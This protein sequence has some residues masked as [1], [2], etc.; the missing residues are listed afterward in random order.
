MRYTL[1]IE[2]S[3]AT[4]R[5]LMAA[6]EKLGGKVTRHGDTDEIRLILDGFEPVAT[7]LGA[8]PEGRGDD[9]HVEGRTDWSDERMEQFVSAL[10]DALAAEKIVYR[11]ELIGPGDDDVRELESAD[12][13]QFMA[14]R[15]SLLGS[16][17][18][19]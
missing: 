2:V 17:G 14:R 13:A 7:P 16:N 4:P 12:F 1:Y 19:A 18:E 3:A 15:E 9:F 8:G 11:I 5:R 10:R 6:F